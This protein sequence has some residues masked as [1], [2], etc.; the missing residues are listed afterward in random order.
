MFWMPAPIRQQETG[1]H[2]HA[3]AQFAWYFNFVKKHGAHGKTPA[4]VAGLTDKPM[5]IENLLNNT[6]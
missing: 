5:T 2:Q 3:L 4:E 1:N 6:L